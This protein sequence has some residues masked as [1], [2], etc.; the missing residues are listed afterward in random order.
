MGFPLRTKGTVNTEHMFSQWGIV[1]TGNSEQ[2]TSQSSEARRPAGP[3]EAKLPQIFFWGVG[4]IKGTGN[5]EQGTG[6][7]PCSPS[8]PGTC[9]GTTPGKPIA[10]K[11]PLFLCSSKR[12]IAISIQE[13]WDESYSEPKNHLAIRTSLLLNRFIKIC[14]SHLR[15]VSIEFITICR[16]QNS[17][18]LSKIEKVAETC[19]FEHLFFER[20]IVIS[21]RVLG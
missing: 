20:T 10:A 2:G 4:I 17:P 13:F 15:P 19:E 14:P 8:V 12:T 7:M 6:N 5:K 11:Q 18:N 9:S 21:R 3:P 16:I 1:G